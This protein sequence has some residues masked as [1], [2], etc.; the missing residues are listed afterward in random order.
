MNR[1]GRSEIKAHKDTEEVIEPGST[2]EALDEVDNGGGPAGS[3][4]GDRHAAGQ[5]AGGDETGGLAGSNIGE[6]RPFEDESE[7]QPEYGDENGP[8]AGHAGG[9]WV[10]RQRRAALPVAQ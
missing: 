6:G 4:L 2:K 5:P 8:Y 3:S 1:R 7:W 9:P 10:A